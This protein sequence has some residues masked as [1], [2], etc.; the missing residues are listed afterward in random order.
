[1]S[2]A[3]LS[4]FLHIINNKGLGVEMEGSKETSKRLWG[5]MY[6]LA[7]IMSQYSSSGVGI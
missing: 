7:S 1:M 3:I 2:V 5:K 6:N 4:S